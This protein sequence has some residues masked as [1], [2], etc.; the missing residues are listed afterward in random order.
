MKGHR[1][2]CVLRQSFYS[3]L[4]I[5]GR[6]ITTS[7]PPLTVWS[8]VEAAVR[9][10]ISSLRT[11]SAGDQSLTAWNAEQNRIR[12]TSRHWLVG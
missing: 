5:M 1:F 3:G 12:R 9:L 2:I 6:T 10:T 7:T 4:K 8:S 11:S